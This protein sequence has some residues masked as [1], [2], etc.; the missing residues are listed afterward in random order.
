MP[1]PAF[2]S[3]PNLQR[4]VPGGRRL[5]QTPKKPSTLNLAAGVLG[6]AIA[7]S[8]GLTPHNLPCV[9]RSPTVPQL[10]PHVTGAI[11]FPK[12]NISPTRGPYANNAQ[13]PPPGPHLADGA[14]LGRRQPYVIGRG[15]HSYPERPM[16]PEEPLSFE[17][18]VA[19]GRGTRQ[20]PSPLPNGYKP[21]DRP[22]QRTPRRRS[23][24]RSRQSDSD[25]D[26]WC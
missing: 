8:G 5:P 7:P 17:Q 21:G 18:G 11:N 6:P 26:D 14:E 4:R 10:G 16:R 19:L 20:L 23:R 2:T 25:E 13:Q 15:G 12:L 3:H 22:R 24:S 9:S 1:R